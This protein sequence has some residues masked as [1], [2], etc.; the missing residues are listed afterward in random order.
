MDNIDIVNQNRLAWNKRVVDGS[1]WTV[2]VDSGTIQREQ[3][4]L[5]FSSFQIGVSMRK[6]ISLLFIITTL[7][8]PAQIT[9]GADALHRMLHADEVESFRQDQDAFIVGELTGRQE[10]SFSVKVLKVV[11]GKVTSDTIQVDDDFTYG[12]NKEIP[13]VGEFAVFSIKKKSGNQY[14]KAWG[15]F[16]ANSGDY[17]SLKLD[18]MNA[19]LPGLMADLACIQW[20]VNSGGKENDFSFISGSAFVKHSDGQVEQIYPVSTEKSLA[21]SAGTNQA[22]STGN[23]LV[24]PPKVKTAQ[25]VDKSKMNRIILMI[26]PVMLML[27]L[28]AATKKKKKK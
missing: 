13:N 4:S 20:Y 18:Q 16:K 23:N 10:G 7:I 12:W 9:H 3:C 2:Y 26:V 6:F 15:I 17:S 25:S 21:T 1:K 11:S 8:I 27:I 28:S 24:I 19:S 22:A 14:R 5:D